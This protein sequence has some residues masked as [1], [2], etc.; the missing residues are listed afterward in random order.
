MPQSLS[1]GIPRWAT[2]RK[3]A[4]VYNCVT[5]H[6]EAPMP[7]V[8]CGK[9]KLGKYAGD[10]MQAAPRWP[11]YN[12]TLRSSVVLI[13]VIVQTRTDHCWPPSLHYVIPSVLV[14]KWCLHQRCFWTIQLW[15]SVLAALRK[16]A[17]N[18]IHH[19]SGSVGSVVAIHHCGGGISVTVTTPDK[20]KCLTTLY[21]TSLLFI[22]LKLCDFIS[23]QWLHSLLKYCAFYVICQIK[24]VSTILSVSCIHTTL[25]RVSAE[26]ERG[27]ILTATLN[28]LFCLLVQKLT[29]FAVHSFTSVM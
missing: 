29:C 28:V 2:I 20:I 16:T 8:Q 10:S 13:P 17:E 18:T 12:C 19:S 22:F 25:R 23:V 7:P 1:L 5:S 6:T 3:A 9:Q 14:L 4:G 24:G 11:A 27:M 15:Y 26:F 21:V